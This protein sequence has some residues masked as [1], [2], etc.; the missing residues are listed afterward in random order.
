MDDKK[1]LKILS[2][3]IRKMA[4][5]AFLETSTLSSDPNVEKNQRKD[6]IERWID[7]YLSIDL[8]EE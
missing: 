1:R 7:N 2:D 4:Y 5:D 3:A 6:W 8:L